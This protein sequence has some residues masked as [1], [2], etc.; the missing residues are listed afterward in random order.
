MINGAT[1]LRPSIDARSRRID[2]ET[3]LLDLESEEYF[4]L[5][6]VGTE[7]WA[8][9]EQGTTIDAMVDE[10]LEV[11]EVDRATLDADL[12]ALVDDMVDAGLVTTDE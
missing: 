6:D 3:L 2:D 12:R 7:A 1:P 11:F 8:R 10:L 9:I 5:G 4:S